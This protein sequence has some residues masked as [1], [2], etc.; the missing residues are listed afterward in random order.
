MTAL[1]MSRMYSSSQYYRYNEKDGLKK[2]EKNG[3]RQSIFQKINK[4]NEYNI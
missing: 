2:K 3:R 1:S 4:I